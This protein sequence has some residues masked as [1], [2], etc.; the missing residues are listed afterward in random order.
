MNIP[1]ID[2]SIIIGYSNLL[3]LM[4]WIYFFDIIK[5]KN[6]DIKIK[7]FIKE[8]NSSKIKLLLNI[9]IVSKL[10]FNMRKIVIGTIII[11]NL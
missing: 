8:E 11:V 6:E 5:T 3:L 10:L 7:I 1:R 9:F 4:S 2:R